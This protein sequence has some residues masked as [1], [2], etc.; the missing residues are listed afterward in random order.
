MRAIGIYALVGMASFAG[1]Y[2][3]A[4]PDPSGLWPNGMAMPGCSIKGNVSYSSGKCQRL[5]NLNDLFTRLARCGAGAKLVLVDACRNELKA[6]SAR[7]SID[8]DRLTIPRGVGAMSMNAV[9]G[10]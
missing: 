7:R 6:E 5:I 10:R 4:G 8:V 2:A 1:V 9:L 3:L